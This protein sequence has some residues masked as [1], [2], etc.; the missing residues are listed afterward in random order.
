MQVLLRRLWRI[1][2]IRWSVSIGV[3]VVVMVVVLTD[4]V[5]FGGGT[6]AVKLVRTGHSRNKSQLVP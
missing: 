2:A 3:P 5:T 4:S 6:T 1:L